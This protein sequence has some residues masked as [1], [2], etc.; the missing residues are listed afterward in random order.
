MVRLRIIHLFHYPIGLLWRRWYPR[1]F[2][3]MQFR[4]TACIIYYTYNTAVS[5]IL[6]L[7][8]YCTYI[9]YTR[10]GMRPTS[11]EMCCSGPERR[12]QVT[13]NVLRTS[14]FNICAWGVRRWPDVRSTLQPPPRCWHA[15]YIYIA[16][17]KVRVANEQAKRMR[18]QPGRKLAIYLLPSFN[19]PQSGNV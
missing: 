10:Y 17:Y 12:R 4:V 15:W 9:Q 14:G 13:T 5:R 3:R 16:L 1:L 19:D 2:G 11:N 8:Q 6:R 7:Y 18:R